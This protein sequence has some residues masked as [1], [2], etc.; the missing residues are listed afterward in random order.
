ML[1]LSTLAFAKKA[2]M[3]VIRTV[4]SFYTIPQMAEIQV[5]TAIS[6][7]LS[8]GHEFKKNEI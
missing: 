4:I 2:D 3:F 6:F 7:Q 1:W 8:K 5:P